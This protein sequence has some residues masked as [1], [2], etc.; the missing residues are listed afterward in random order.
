MSSASV[1]D[2]KAGA[3]SFSGVTDGVSG[4]VSSGITVELSETTMRS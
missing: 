1:V 4:G 2:S 3:A